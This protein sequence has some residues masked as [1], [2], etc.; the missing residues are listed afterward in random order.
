MKRS[1]SVFS[2]FGAKRILAPQTPLHESPSQLV[3]DQLDR[4]TGN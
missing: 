1:I 4:N 3:L 2:S